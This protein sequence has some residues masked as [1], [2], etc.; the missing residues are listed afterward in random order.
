M[1]GLSLVQTSLAGLD[2]PGQS[3]RTVAAPVDFDA[4][5]HEQRRAIVA[6][7]VGAMS[8]PRGGVGLAAPMTGVGLRVIVCAHDGRALAMAN[9]EIVATH[10]ETVALMEA[11]LSLPGVSARVRRPEA[12]SVTWQSLNTGRRREE[13]FDG[14]LG[15]IVQ[16]ELD[17]LDGRMFTDLVR[18]AE[19]RQDPPDRERAAGAAAA[20]FGEPAAELVPPRARL[21]VVTL[22]PALAGLGASVL[23]RP[24][25]PLD[26]AAFDPADLRALIQA[27][28][29]LQYGHAGVGLAAPQVGLSLRLAV[30]D[31]RDGAP[32]ALINPERLDASDELTVVAEGCLSIPG[33]R[34]PVERPAAIR[35]RNH[36]VAGEPYELEAEGYLARVIQHEMD[37]LDGVLYTDRLLE[38]LAPDGPPVRA[39]ETLHAIQREE[40]A[41]SARAAKRR[42]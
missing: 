16:H 9:P 7:V 22:P 23:R 19:L 12:V 21:N 17:L 4:V 29:E 40:A 1:G 39:E 41:D 37:H 8:G 6:G 10:G 18:P 35:V 26:V 28:F 33:W 25:D 20:V 14:Y 42:R 36:T 31:D 3:L 24:A 2:W 30:I 32:L 5:P 34:G 38:A 13:T 15:R 11:N 27:M